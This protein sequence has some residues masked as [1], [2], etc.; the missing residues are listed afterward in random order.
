MKIKYTDMNG[1]IKIDRGITEHW[2]W[3]DP[4]KFYWWIDMLMLANWKDR[5]ELVKNTLVLVRRGQ[6]LASTNQLARRWKVGEAP[7][8]VFLRLL[9]QDGMITR[10]YTSNYNLF[11][12]SNYEKY[13]S[14]NSTPDSTPDAIPDH[15][16][17]PTPDATPIYEER[18]KERMKESNN[19]PP[20]IYPPQGGRISGANSRF[21]RPTSEQ[22]AEYCRERKNGIDAEAFCNYYDS[23]GWKVG[24][25]PMKDW[26]A[27]VRTW[28]RRNRE[29]QQERSAANPNP[30]VKLGY[31]ERIAEDGR[32]MLCNYVIPMSAPP[33]PTPQHLW[34]GKNERWILV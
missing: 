34:D 7:V 31:G 24:K 4:Q 25:K 8:K 28:E 11:S 32:R 21:V 19:I 5:K 22:V 3:Q 20:Y 10:E 6:I 26:K 1:W 2:L 18:K 13:Q 30:S 23:V 9:E 15:T 16:L 14:L 33:R 27:A 29:E 12:I 17:N